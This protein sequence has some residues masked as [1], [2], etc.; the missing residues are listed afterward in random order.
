[1]NKNISIVIPVYRSGKLLEEL[2]SRLS[3]VLS[4]ITDNWEIIFVDD[5]SND[6]TFDQLNKL[7]VSDNRIKLIRFSCNMGQHHATLCGLQRAK[8]D[9]II[10][11]DDDLQNPPEEIPKFLE[12]IDDG[13]DIV[14]GNITGEKKHNI[15]RNISSYIVD[16][17][18]TNILAKPKNIKLSS[19]RAMSKRAVKKM[20]SMNKSTH[21]YIPALMFKSVPIK[22]ICNIPVRHDPRLNGKSTYTVKKLIKLLSYLLIN[23]SRTPLRIATIWGFIISLVSFSYALFIVIKVIM[24]GSNIS[25]WPSLAVLISFTSGNILFCI[26]VLGEYIGRLLDEKTIAN[27]FPIFEEYM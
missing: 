12:K 6:D 9:Y 19:Y 20:S 10:T 16:I 23:H 17:L 26:G 1:M 24:Y 3:I 18:I 4:S 5:G 2:F 11:L 8:G 25:G 15:F 22:N 21:I 13:F 7:R 27:Q 14:I